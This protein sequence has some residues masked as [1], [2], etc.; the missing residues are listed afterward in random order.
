MFSTRSLFNSGA[1]ARFSMYMAFVDAEWY[2]EAI[3]ESEK[4]LLIAGESWLWKANGM[5]QLAAM[6]AILTSASVLLK[7]SLDVAALEKVSLAWELSD[8]ALSRWP[9][10]LHCLMTSCF[11]MWSHLIVLLH[12]LHRNL[13]YKIIIVK[14]VDRDPYLHYAYLCWSWDT[15]LTKGNS[16]FQSGLNVV[17][18]F[19]AP[20]SFRG[21][22]RCGGRAS[23]SSRSV[24]VTHSA[25]ES[26]MLEFKL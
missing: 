26:D 8:L 19:A 6:T 18:Y 1:I 9:W 2:F 14:I 23:S 20:E 17:Q 5:L 15:P 10:V 12:A 11:P 24:S 13:Q 4:R 21:C 3:L 7:T 25:S 16:F 22:F